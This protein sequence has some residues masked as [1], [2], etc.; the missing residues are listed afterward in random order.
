MVKIQNNQKKEKPSYRK[1][2]EHFI[3]QWHIT[4]K[5]PNQCLHCYLRDPETYNSEINKELKFND[6][7]KII[8]D[9]SETVKRWDIIGRINFTGGDP[10]LRPDVF[11]LISYARRKDLTVGIL[12]NPECIDFETAKKLKD[13]GV[14]RYQ[15]SICGMKETHDRIVSPGSF[16]RT[17][18]AID[19][20]NEVGL[21]PVV[22]FTVSK[23]NAD[24][25]LEVI[26]L[27]VQKKVFLFGFTRLVPIGSGKQLLDDLLTP[28]E[29]RKLLLKVFKKYKQLEED[30]CMTSFGKR[31]SLWALIYREKGFFKTVENDNKTI[32]GGCAVGISS[33]AVLADGTVYPCRRLPI[34]IGEI[35]K[36]KIRDIFVKSVKLNEL[37]NV[38]NME[39]CSKCELLQYCRGCPAIAYAVHGNFF[40]PDPQCWK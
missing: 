17:L 11:D 40:S 23:Q 6:C 34:K 19:I 10:L 8:D 4:A 26:D 29:H 13:L 12:G 25:L 21:P 15:V 7:I 32:Y 22:M 2:S 3:L 39:K 38:N 5:C 37:R 18:S 30:N 36:E 35:P 27:V 33:L 24:E 28:D 16:E 20:L 31:D 9:F 14:L 1:H